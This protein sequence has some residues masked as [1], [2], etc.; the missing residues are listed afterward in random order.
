MRSG[1]TFIRKRLYVNVL[2][3]PSQACKHNEL[4]IDGSKKTASHS[5]CICFEDTV[6]KTLHC[7]TATSSKLYAIGV[8]NVDSDKAILDNGTLLSHVSIMASGG[9][10]TIYAVIN[11]HDSTVSRTCLD[12][13][14][15][16]IC[17]TVEGYG[18]FGFCG[19]G[20]VAGVVLSVW[21]RKGFS[22]NKYK[23][24]M[25]NTLENNCLK[26]NCVSTVTPKFHA[27]ASCVMFSL[28]RGVGKKH[29][30]CPIVVIYQQ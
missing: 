5:M 18:T 9:D 21:A 13:C 10:E 3:P 4:S 28:M 8:P 17:R 27:E 16:L 20:V 2:M 23:C 12:I 29:Q 15:S 6:L 30:V 11:R 14:L 19:C 25:V 22:R 7:L 26:C 24:A 1:V